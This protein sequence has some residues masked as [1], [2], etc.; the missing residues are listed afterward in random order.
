MLFASGYL[1]LKEVLRGVFDDLNQA[2]FR[3]NTGIY[4]AKPGEFVVVEL[5]V[6]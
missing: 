1:D 5:V 6:I 3:F 2:H 4:H